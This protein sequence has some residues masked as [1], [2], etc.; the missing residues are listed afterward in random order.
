MTPE[1]VA[2]AMREQEAAKDI[3]NGY[4]LT[5]EDYDRL[6]F[7]TDAIKEL[8][9]MQVIYLLTM[10]QLCLALSNYRTKITSNNFLERRG[11]VHE[12]SRDSRHSLLLR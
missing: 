2:A 7:E 10:S 4:L 6:Y 9:E 5:Q 11:D 8:R 12:G 1:E 3:E